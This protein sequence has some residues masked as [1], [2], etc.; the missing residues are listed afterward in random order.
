MALENFEQYV[1]QRG[2][3][4]YCRWWWSGHHIDTRQLIQVRQPSSQGQATSEDYSRYDRMILL[5]TV[6]SH[7]G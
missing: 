1:F 5:A 3:K 4:P 6:K 7:V 2:N